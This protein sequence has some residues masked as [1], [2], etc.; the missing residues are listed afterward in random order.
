V[1]SA[2]ENLKNYVGAEEYE[3][4]IAEI[5]IAVNADDYDTA[6][7]FVDA[8]LAAEEGEEE[9]EEEEEEEQERRHLR[10]AK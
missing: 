10:F 8:L 5:E 6:R 7:E 4:Q 9:E 1:L 2:L 3:V